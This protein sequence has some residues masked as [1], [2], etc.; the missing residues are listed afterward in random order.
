MK[1]VSLKRW[2]DGNTLASRRR[3]AS[4]IQGRHACH[5]RACIPWRHPP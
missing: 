1:S 2:S 3:P 5:F 4:P